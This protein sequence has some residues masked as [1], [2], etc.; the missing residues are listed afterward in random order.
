MARYKENIVHKRLKASIYIAITLFLGLGARLYYLQI[1]D[2]EDLKLASLKQRSVEINLNSSRGIIFD[3]NLNL[4]TNEETTKTIIIEKDILLNNDELM[5]DIKLKT[6][7]TKKEFNE[8]L[9]VKNSLLK[10]PVKDE[11]VIEENN[12]FA[13]DIINRYSNNNLLSHVIGYV[14]K[15]ENIG[16]SGIEKVYDE[17]LNKTDKESLFV[18]YDKSRSMILGGS[19]YAD[20]SLSFDD[21]LGVQ[22]TIDKNLQSKVEKI[23]DDEKIKGAVV[24]AEVETAEIIA[25]ASRPNF[26]Q[27]SI[28]NHLFNDDMALYNKAIQVSY[29]PGSIFKI[30]VVLAGLEKNPDYINHDF[31][32]RGYEDVKGLIIKCS[33]INGHGNISLKDGFAKSCNSVF[34]QMGKELGSD[35]VIDM[36]RRLGFGEKVNIGLIEEIKGNLPEGND[37]LGP[38]IGNISLGQGEIET[39][40]LQVTNMLLTIANNGIQKDMT[41]VKGITSKNGRMIKPFNKVEDKRITDLDSVK[42]TQ[43]LLEEVLES[44]TGSS[45]D[46]AEIGGGGGKTGSAQAYLKKEPIVHGWFTGYYPK[47]NPEYAITV[48][49]EEANSGSKS[50]APIFEKICKEIYK[51]K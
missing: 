22:L 7:L 28:E 44:G 13:M 34:I 5:D 30:V 36:A 6:K 29:P 33:N 19:Y 38:A 24:V 37:L 31:Y 32:C 18:E 25:L 42:I 8:S 15:A 4:L 12:F 50:A 45:L 48:L 21:P 11:L 49:V 51:S 14:N 2:S 40:P 20:N 39:T 3:R 41:I 9:E 26:N 35:K 27:D 46:L 10:I 17:F 16:K 47:D 1:Y 23:L 43:E